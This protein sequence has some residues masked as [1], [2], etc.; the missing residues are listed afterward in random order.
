MFPCKP[1][2]T[3]I[4]LGFLTVSLNCF[5][6]SLICW[7]NFTSPHVGAS[8]L[9]PHFQNRLRPP[10][11]F[12]LLQQHLLKYDDRGETLQIFYYY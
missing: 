12:K 9:F 3:H 5:Q 4:I 10:A 6:K 11:M 1:P 7:N 2:Y 8:D